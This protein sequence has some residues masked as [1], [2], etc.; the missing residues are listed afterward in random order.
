M[1]ACEPPLAGSTV[2]ILTIEASLP[3][4]ITAAKAEGAEMIILMAHVSVTRCA[5]AAAA[6]AQLLVGQPLPLLPPQRPLPSSP[7]C[8]S[9]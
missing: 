5:A 3:G 2:D 1:R 6:A 8:C 9:W 4:C 7:L